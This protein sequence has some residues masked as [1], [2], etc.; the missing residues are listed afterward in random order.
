M[1]CSGY[2]S[3]A[4]NLFER[5]LL[6]FALGLTFPGGKEFRVGLFQVVID[7]NIQALGGGINPFGLAFNFAKVADGRFIDYYVTVGVAPFTAKLFIPEAGAEAYRFNDPAHGISVFD[8]RLNL[9]AGFVPAGLLPATVFISQRPAWTILAKAKKGSPSAQL[10]AGLIVKGVHFM[11]AGGN[12]SKSSLFQ[13]GGK[14]LDVI[15]SEL[16]LDF[17]VGSHSASIKEERRAGR[18]RASQKLFWHP[19]R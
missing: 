15:D 12:Q 8:L 10:A 1:R 2:A 13:A 5:H 9:S 6:R 4:L 14:G 11:S 17:A 7:W 19:K 16:D 3:L 18:R